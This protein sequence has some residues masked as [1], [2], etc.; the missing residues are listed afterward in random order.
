MARSGFRLLALVGVLVLAASSS[1][2]AHGPRVVHFRGLINDYTI[3]TFGSWEV[4]GI[5]TLD[6]NQ[7]SNRADFTATLTMERS[8]LFFVN[9]AADPNSL[10]ARNAHTHH[11]A[12][13]NAVVTP[14][15]G[16]FRLSGPA[17]ITGNGAPAPFETSPPTSTLQIDIIGGS[18]V[19]FSNIT[20]TFGGAA[21]R[22]FG[23][24]PVAGAVRAWH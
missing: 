7:K 6:V 11:I 17:T 15:A 2:Q 10:E 5:W 13:R 12:V 23:S 8:D 16:G 22:H 20:L 21:V 3:P 9:T 24:E 14:I 4:R 19:T 1:G 18:L